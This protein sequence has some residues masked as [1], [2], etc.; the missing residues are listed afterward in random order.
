MFVVGERARL[1]RCLRRLA[2]GSTCPFAR[3]SGAAL[4]DWGFV[5]DSSLRFRGHCTKWNKMKA[6]SFRPRGTN[7]LRQMKK[8]SLHFSFSMPWRLSRPLQQHLQITISSPFSPH[9]WHP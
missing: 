8:N 7:G 5:I 9:E 6:L 1:G 4:Q 2:E 3:G